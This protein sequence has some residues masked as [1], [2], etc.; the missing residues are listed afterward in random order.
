MMN[1]AMLELADG[2]VALIDPEDIGRVADYM[3]SLPHSRVAKHPVTTL[4]SERGT[5][6]TI[7][8]HRLIANA[9]PD[10]IVVHRNRNPLDNRRDNLAVM[11]RHRVPA[12]LPAISPSRDAI[13]AD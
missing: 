13:P 11:G 2:T 3:W 7:Y 4:C 6:D 8:L 1:A 10:D 9:G 5:C 12:Y